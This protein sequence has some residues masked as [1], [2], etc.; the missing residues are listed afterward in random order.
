[1]KRFDHLK[2]NKSSFD[3]S[4]PSFKEC[5]EQAGKRANET[6][7]A[8][9]SSQEIQGLLNRRKGLYLIILKAVLLR[10][11]KGINFNDDLKVLVQYSLDKLGAFAKTEIYFAWKMLKHGKKYRFFEPISQLGKK[12]VHKIRGMSWDLYSIRYQEILACKSNKGDFFIPFFASF[13]NRFVELAKACPIR[14]IIIDDRDKRVM[15]VH[16]DDSE[17]MLDL[18]NSITTELRNRLQ[19]PGEKI[20]RLSSIPSGEDLD[21]EIYSLEKELEKYC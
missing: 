21:K 8:F 14:A 10:D 13:D 4:N 1:M 2:Y 5:R 17:F 7:H 20:K 6:L 11:K 18:E 15:T 12:S 3:V 19:D 16:L 9:H